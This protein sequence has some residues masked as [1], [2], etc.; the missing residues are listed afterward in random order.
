MGGDQEGENMSK[1]AIMQGERSEWG[2]R[3]G[4][5][6]CSVGD[7]SR[8]GAWC[9]NVTCSISSYRDRPEV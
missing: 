9:T 1:H 7:K 8:P 5:A 2:L 4:G 3:L 6:G